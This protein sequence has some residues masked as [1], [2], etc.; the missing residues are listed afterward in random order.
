MQW[1]RGVGLATLIWLSGC[2]GGGGTTTSAGGGSGS[3]TGGSPPAPPASNITLN[4]QVANFSA[5]KVATLVKRNSPNVEQSSSSSVVSVVARE[6]AGP[7]KDLPWQDLEQKVSSLAPQARLDPT[8]RARAGGPFDGTVEGTDYSFFVI[9][10]NSTVTCRKMHAD[11]E[12][13]HCIVMAEVVGGSPVISKATALS[14]AAAFDQ[15]NPFAPGSGIYDQDR[16]IFGHEWDQAGGRDGS[17]KIVL[18]FLSGSTIGNQYYGFFNP[19][20]EFSKASDP[21]SNEGEMLYLN[22]N[23][24]AGDNFDILSTIAH[25]FQHCICFNTKFARQGAFSGGQENAAINEGKSVLAEDLL[26]YGLNATGGGNSFTFNA[27]QS[28][29]NNPGRVGVFTFD[30]TADS[31]GRPYTLMRYLVD[32]FGLTAFKSYAQSAGIGLAQLN[33]SYGSFTSIFGDWV[34][35]NLST[36]LGGSVPLVWRYTS[37]YNPKG[38][39][40]IRGQGNVSLPGWRPAATSS[41]PSGSQFAN[42]GAWAASTVEY[43]GGTGAT[44]NLSVTGPSSIGGNVLVEN[45]RGTYE[46]FR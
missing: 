1:Y 6:Q 44:L 3:T 12:T 24:L 29:L 25:E 2:G 41:P 38:S 37:A 42:L 45:P 35:A 8:V 33:A 13:T 19:A 14:L 28:F 26:G 4:F 10:S 46:G 20:D 23:R 18:L 17:A 7:L 27:C 16:A 5:N 30:Q 39:Y 21:N 31:Y 40:T 36:P 32:R 9:T 15:N 22:A 11:A 43:S 34:M